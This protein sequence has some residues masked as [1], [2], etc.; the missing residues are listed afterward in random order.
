[1]VQICYNIHKV[2]NF[3]RKKCLKK[4]LLKKV[5]FKS[6]FYHFFVKLLS[7]NLDIYDPSLL[8]KSVF[9]R[10][11]GQTTAKLININMLRVIYQNY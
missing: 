7:I 2:L 5:A 4:Y 8:L 11:V 9:L 3:H 6:I 1:M 10:N